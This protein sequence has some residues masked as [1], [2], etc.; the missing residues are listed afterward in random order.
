MEG[1]YTDAFD[2]LM[3]YA[4]EIR[5]VYGTLF[6]HDQR[7]ERNSKIKDILQKYSADKTPCLE[8]VDK[9]LRNH[10]N[11]LDYDKHGFLT[12]VCALRIILENL[13]ERSDYT[14]HNGRFSAQLDK[15]LEYL[16]LI[17]T[18]D[19]LWVRHDDIYIT[20]PPDLWDQYF[21]REP[22]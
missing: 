7:S 22:Q 8:E 12:Y 3:K 16:Y 9:C 17:E 15:H 18:R 5:S 19:R 21:K 13:L 10:N 4:L 1:D 6:E 2:L 11:F 14:G 20:L